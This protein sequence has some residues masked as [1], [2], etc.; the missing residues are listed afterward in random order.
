MHISELAEL[1]RNYPTQISA[2]AAVAALLVSFLSIVLTST[3]LWL[4]RRHYFKS[5]TPIANILFGDYE[6]LIRVTIR[7]NGVGPL[8]IKRF[9]VSNGQSVKDDLISWMPELPEGIYWT[10]FTANIDG[11]CITPNQALTILQLDGDISNIDFV[12]FRDDI[13]Q[14]LSL[15]TA[16]LEYRDIY[17]RKMPTDKR[18]L[19]WFARNL[20]NRDMSSAQ[21]NSNS[22]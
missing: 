10:N 21:E 13:R 11:R 8:L 2:L 17:R 9:T 6:N 16:T 18:S 5:V 22:E 19:E 20:I 15:L 3:A 1:L 12:A 4:Q 7:N 14:V